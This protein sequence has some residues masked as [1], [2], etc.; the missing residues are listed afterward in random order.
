MKQKFWGN[1]LLTECLAVALDVKINLVQKVMNKDAE[2]LGYK[3]TSEFCPSGQK[4]L[5][6]LYS[7]NQLHCEALI[8]QN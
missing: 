6:I 7:A 2:E 3:V 4:E 1:E 5:S 8:P